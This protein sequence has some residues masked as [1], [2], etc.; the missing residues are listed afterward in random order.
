MIK[1]SGIGT[2]HKDKIITIRLCMENKI[3]GG[4][5]NKNWK[6]NKISINLSSLDGDLA[7]YK[8]YLLEDIQQETSNRLSY[9]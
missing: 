7:D 4:T 6:I 2:V 3:W 9:Q 1:H 5:C 8:K